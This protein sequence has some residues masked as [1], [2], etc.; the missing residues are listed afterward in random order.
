[1]KRLLT[2]TLPLAIA[3]VFVVFIVSTQ[4]TSS[5]ETPADKKPAAMP[6]VPD[7]AETATFAAGCYWCVEAVFQRLDGVYSVTSGFTG[8]H[9]ENP[10][11]QAVC[12]GG[13]GHAESVQIIFD[14]KKISYEK[15]LG[16]FWRS[17]DPTQ[18][19]RQGADIGSHYRTAIFYHNETQKKQ[20]IASRNKAQESFAKPIVTEITKAS[21]FFPAKDS[22]QDYYRINGSK[23][24]YCRAVIAPKLKK[25]KLDK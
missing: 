4:T 13:T 10:T 23:D 7:G 20:A 11:Y 12:D 9:I 15:L 3:G 21:K 16:W 8:G 19:N 24:P 5:Q 25:L 2:I 6:A 14:P 17:H 22:H 18:L 1:M